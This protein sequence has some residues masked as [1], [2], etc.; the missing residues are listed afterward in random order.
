MTLQHASQDV[1]GFSCMHKETIQTSFSV[2]LQT[3][4]LYIYINICNK[5][6]KLAYIVF[7]VYTRESLFTPYRTLYS[8]YGINMY[9]VLKYI[10]IYSQN[11]VHIDC[12]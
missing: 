5:T 3:V 7:L 2:L 12:L 10:Y 11:Y 1:Q 8:P 9:I 4:K 6:Q